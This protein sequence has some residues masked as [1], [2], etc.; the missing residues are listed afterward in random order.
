MVFVFVATS[1]LHVIAFLLLLFV[2]AV[3]VV[4][5]ISRNVFVQ[6]NDIYQCHC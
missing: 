5:K 4:F 6:G 2:V 1:L 3:V